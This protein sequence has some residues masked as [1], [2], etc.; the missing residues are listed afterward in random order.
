M[1]CAALPVWSLHATVEEW[2]PGESPDLWLY[3]D[4]TISLLRRFLHLSL[5]AGR[6]PSLLGREIFRAKVTSYRMMTFEDVVIFVHDVERCLERLDEFSRELIARITLQ[7]YTH[8][9]AAHILGCCRKTIQRRYPEAL[10]HL[11]E[12]FLEVGLL[13]PVFCGRKSHVKQCH[14]N[15]T[16]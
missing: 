14:E 10:D 16:Q 9:E 5:E 2:D 4:R 11:S 12:I 1:N 6:V 13:Q 15:R 7:E 3:R 8:A